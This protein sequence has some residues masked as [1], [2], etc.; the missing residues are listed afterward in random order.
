[1]SEFIPSLKPNTTGEVDAVYSAQIVVDAFS[2]ALSE[3]NCMTQALIQGYIQA[4]D[5]QDQLR[6]MS[7]M[8]GEDTTSSAPSNNI[9]SI[10]TEQYAYNSTY[11]NED[12]PIASLTAEIK[13]RISEECVDCSLQDLPEL[14]LDALQNILDDI[15]AFINGLKL[16]W[17][18][19]GRNHCHIIYLLSQVCLPDLIKLLAI[20]LAAIVKLLAEIGWNTFSM[21]AF[22]AGI[23]AAILSALFN[24]VSALV[25]YALSPIS[26][27]IETVKTVINSMPTP[28]NL[29]ENLSEQ[30]AAVIGISQN[31]GNDGL[32]TATENAVDRFNT[33]LANDYRNFEGNLQNSFDWILDKVEYSYSVGVLDSINNLTGMFEAVNCEDKRTG[34]GIVEKIQALYELV[35][36]ANLIAAIIE[37]KSKKKI[38]NELCL[39][40]EDGFSP[41]N[42]PFDDREI[43]KT[44]SDTYGKMTKIVESDNGNVGILLTDEPA[45]SETPRLSLNSC[46]LN[47]FI[48]ESH[49]DKVI[50]RSVAFAEDVLKGDG[51]DP[52]IS[53]IPSIREDELT[54]EERK[55]V[56]LFGDASSLSAEITSIIDDVISFNR[57]NDSRNSTSVDLDIKLPSNTLPDDNEASVNNNRLETQIEG[58]SGNIIS[59]PVQLKCGTIDNLK[60]TLSFIKE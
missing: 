29:R 20:V 45:I 7:N 54:E 25:A 39:G 38:Y 41:S 55:N 44:V 47:D 33:Q 46:S 56:L 9:S 4:D 28:D 23:V 21:T 5:Y 10:R 36:V 17:E 26:C 37:G 34:P 24:Y 48:G 59:K 30:E 40:I 22:T 32:D 8:L 51:Q 60:D 43:A 49:T 19:R 6:N 15:N 57:E 31:E 3:N 11:K 52:L 53:L 27:T 42:D 1:M 2:K 50:E 35:E 18:S 16:L 58:I 13:S 12:D 14:N